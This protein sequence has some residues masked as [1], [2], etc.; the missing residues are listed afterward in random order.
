LIDDSEIKIENWLS[1]RIVDSFVKLENEAFITGDGTN[2][3]NGFLVNGKIKQIDGGNSVSPDKLL[4]LMNNLDEGYLANASFV[5][6]RKTLS[7]IQGLKDKEGRFIWTQS[8]ADPLKQTIFGI[9]VYVSSH[10]PDVAKDKLSIALGDF[11]SAYKIVDRAE[12]NLMRDPY[13]E[14]PFVKF[15][16]VKRVGGDV[17][18]PSAIKLAKFS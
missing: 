13:T 1:E 6:N 12:I 15:Y 14:K 2:K 8:L 18:N 7:S 16:A 9:L 17:V 5:M 4:Y 10:M 11:K 3:P